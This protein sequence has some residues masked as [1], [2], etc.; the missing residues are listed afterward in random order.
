MIPSTLRRLVSVLAF[1]FVFA[2]AALSQRPPT[3]TW[4]GAGAELFGTKRTLYVVTIAHPKRRHT[5][6]MQAISATDVVCTH[7]G[8]TTTYRADDVAALI[9]PGTHTGWYFYAIGFLAASGAATWGTVVLSSVCAPCAVA[10]GIVAFFLFWM[11][12]ASAMMT[13]GDTSDRL[14]YLASGQTLKAKLS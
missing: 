4:E 10:T 13:D 6:L 14:L 9:L 1:A 5:C 8:H 12:P 3:S 11:A 2:G 7:H